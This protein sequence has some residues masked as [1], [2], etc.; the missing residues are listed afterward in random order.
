MKRTGVVA[1]LLALTLATGC[2]SSEQTEAQEKVSTVR[3]VQADTR[4][5]TV[6]QPGAPIQVD[7]YVR[8]LNGILAATDERMT[9]AE[10]LALAESMC[11][12]LDVGNSPYD[13]AQML[14]ESGFPM[15]YAE[16]MVPKA[17]A[18]ACTEHL[19]S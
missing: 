3:A 8:H 16:S 12:F 7:M 17:I 15:E 11:N 9:E 5:S 2:G 4:S 10:A 18:A 19:S 14:A 13:A 6:R 1:I